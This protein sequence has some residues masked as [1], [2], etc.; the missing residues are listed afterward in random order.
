MYFF[1]TISGVTS[2][3]IFQLLVY[4]KAG[5]LKLLLGAHR[6]FYS[7]LNENLFINYI[8]INQNS[9]TK[10]VTQVSNNFLISNIKKFEQIDY[11]STLDVVEI[12][13]STLL[14]EII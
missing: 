11:V 10:F 2:R 13:K 1:V 12:D 5:Y 3:E 7:Q 8:E 14:K 4:S 6:V 9:T